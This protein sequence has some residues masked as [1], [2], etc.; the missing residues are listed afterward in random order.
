MGIR[1]WSEA[2]TLLTCGFEQILLHSVVVLIYKFHS[3]VYQPMTMFGTVNVNF[4]TQI[5]GVMELGNTLLYLN[6]F[7]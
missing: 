4:C 7:I 3:R 2:I 6:M 5:T 1:K